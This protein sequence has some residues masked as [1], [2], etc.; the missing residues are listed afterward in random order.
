MCGIAGIAFHG[1]ASS[2]E[3]ARCSLRSMMDIQAHRGPD[4]EGTWGGEADGVGLVLG[5]KRLAII[6]LSPAAAQPMVS[7]SGQQVLIYNGELYNY[8]ELRR[9]LQREGCTFRTQ[10]DAEVVLTA[11]I[12]WGERAFSEFNGM[13]ALAFL[14]LSARTL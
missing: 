4:G 1:R 9:V 13:W 2:S 8:L 10:S 5:H 12:Y 3:E 14:D 7:A 11:L 6:D